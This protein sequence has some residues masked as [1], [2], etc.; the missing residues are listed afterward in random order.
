MKRDKKGAKTVV[1]TAVK[2]KKESKAINPDHAKMQRLIHLLQ[3][4]QIELE[5]QNLELRLAQEE[6]EVSRNKYVNLFDF[7]PIPYFTLDPASI[8]K[9]ANF[10]ASKLLGIERKKLIGKRL[11]SFIPLSEK[12][13][14]GLFIKAILNSNIKHSCE[15][16]ILDKDKN[17]LSVRFEG[18]VLDNELDENPK[19]QV[20][21]IYLERGEGERKK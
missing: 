9:E 20:A 11:S 6:L 10:S 13:N 16:K 19:L 15:S 3:V 5:H 21:L 2:K 1:K 17:Q 18:L 12:G 7:A 4:H 8:I 14:F